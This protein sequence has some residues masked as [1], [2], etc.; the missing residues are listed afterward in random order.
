MSVWGDNTVLP[1]N[2]AK[3]WKSRGQAGDS[4]KTVAIAQVCP[5]CGAAGCEMSVSAGQPAGASRV[6]TIWCVY[7][8][9]VSRDLAID[10]GEW[11]NGAEIGENAANNDPNIR[12]L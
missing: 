6:A 8:R 1:R 12:L 3:R 5:P 11:Q 4:Q 9:V 7:L 2:F 10:S